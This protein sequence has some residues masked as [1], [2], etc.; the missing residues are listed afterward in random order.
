MTLWMNGRKM[1]FGEFQNDFHG[2]LSVMS[3]WAPVRETPVITAQ[4]TFQALSLTVVSLI[5]QL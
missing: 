2:L 4:K 1:G 3:L 5:Y